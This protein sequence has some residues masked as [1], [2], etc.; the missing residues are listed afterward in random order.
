MRSVCPAACLTYFNERVSF[1]SNIPRYCRYVPLVSVVTSLTMVVLVLNA[2]FALDIC[3]SFVVVFT[4]LWE[5]LNIYIYIYIHTY[6]VHL[7]C[8]KVIFI[9]LCFILCVV[10][11]INWLLRYL[12]CL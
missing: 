10:P 6:N 11:G 8:L 12:Y 3:K 4:S 1:T 7:D 9:L 2:A 5:C